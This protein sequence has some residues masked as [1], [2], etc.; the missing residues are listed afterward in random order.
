VQQPTS[1]SAPGHVVGSPPDEL[2]LVDEEVLV[3]LLVVV[4]DV[5]LL[6]LVVDEEVLVL[7]LVVVEDVLLLVVADVLLAVDVVLVDAAPPLPPPP[8]EVPLDVP[9]IVHMPEQ[10]SARQASRAP[11]VALTMQ[12][13]DGFA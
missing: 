11:K 13:S 3:L 12:S 8:P 7:L 10:R 2:L 1:P 9:P 5:L 6:V 4:E